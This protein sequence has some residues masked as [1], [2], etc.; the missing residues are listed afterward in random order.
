MENPFETHGKPYA[1]PIQNP[2]NTPMESVSKLMEY[3]WK[4]Y[5]KVMETL[6]KTYGKP[7]ENSSNPKETHQK[8]MENLWKLETQSE[9]M[10][11][12]RKTC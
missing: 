10:E 4:T 3:L 1:K 2:W 11:I 5:S 8:T 9:L 6:W 12:L 7:M